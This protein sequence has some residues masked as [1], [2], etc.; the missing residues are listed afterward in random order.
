MNGS[1]EIRPGRPEDA[2]ACAKIVSDWIAGTAW[3]G[4]GPGYA[5]LETAIAEGM[6][7]RE[8]HVIGDPVAGYLSLNR[9]TQQVMGLYVARPGEGL[10]RALMDRAKEGRS[11]LQL[12]SHTPNTAAHRFYEREGFTVVERDLMDGSDGVP[13]I[14]MEWRA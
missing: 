7:L 8:F 1:R 6:P 4:D 14:R 9:E 5:A 12:R 10:G 3:I 11:Y 2:P 13:E